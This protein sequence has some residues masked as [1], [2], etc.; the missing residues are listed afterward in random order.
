MATHV[1]LFEDKEGEMNIKGRLTVMLFVVCMLSIGSISYSAE[2]ESGALSNTPKGITDETAGVWKINA[3]LCSVRSED[4]SKV[5]KV[6]RGQN[7]RIYAILPK[8]NKFSSAMVVRF[9]KT[10]RP[11]RTYAAIKYNRTSE[12]LNTFCPTV[13]EIN[14]ND[15]FLILRKDIADIKEFLPVESEKFERAADSKD[16]A[17]V[18][19]ADIC[20]L[21][22]SK[23]I[24]HHAGKDSQYYIL[25]GNL[26][27]NAET[28]KFKEIRDLSTASACPET[29]LPAYHE[30]YILY[31]EKKDAVSGMKA[32]PD[33]YYSEFSK[34]EH[35]VL[36]VP[37]KYRDHDKS[38]TGETTL[39]YYF[40][41]SYDTLWL[42]PTPF[43]T[44][45]LAQIPIA[46]SAGVV[47][48]KNGLSV[49]FG[50]VLRDGEFQVALVAGMD[51]LGG[52]AGKKW[53]YE[54]NV[55]VSIGLGYNIAR[56]NEKMPK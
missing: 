27:K 8:D 20:N 54:D 33:Y 13:P 26:E 38:L 43:I 37:F 52:D 11:F 15:Y 47:E 12:E 25:P 5:Y 16:N 56:K 46:N 31:T 22:D 2:S 10:P 44:F 7:F 34:I 29:K 19:K 49:G 45:G 50:L 4:G 48:N 24:P 14:E 51:H 30:E 55:W 28:I 40:G 18:V 32:V 9:V 21:Y 3:D 41:I 1:K 53:E 17:W 23:G 35:G 39:G 36:V 6:R 42:D